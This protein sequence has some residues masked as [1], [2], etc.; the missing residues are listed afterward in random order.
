MTRDAND[1]WDPTEP[2][3]ADSQSSQPAKGK[4]FLRQFLEHER[5]L[6]VYILTLLKKPGRCGR[7]A[8]GCYAKHR[9]GTPV[10]FST[11]ALI[12]S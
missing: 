1:R 3:S 4:V 7:R 5:R 11:D 6:Y 9:N 8:S 10:L 2:S 12:S